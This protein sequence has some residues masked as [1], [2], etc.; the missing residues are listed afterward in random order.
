MIGAT[1]S[2]AHYDLYKETGNKNLFEEVLDK[3]VMDEHLDLDQDV[4]DYIMSEDI[5]EEKRIYILSN[6]LK[7][8]SL[9]VVNSFTK[10]RDCDT[11]THHLNEALLTLNKYIKV[12]QQEVKKYG[13]VFTPL[14]LVKEM[15]TT[16]PKEVWSNPNLK[17]L[18]PANGMGNFPL[19]VIYKLMKGLESWEPNVEKRYKHIIENM[20][21]VCEL[22]PKNA[23]MYLSLIDPKDDL[24]VN[25]YCGSFLEE[26]FDYHMKNVWDV[27]NFDIVLGNPPYNR[28]V[29][30]K[31]LNK[32]YSISE[33]VLFVHPS[34]WLI[35]ERNQY[36]P[37]LSSKNLVRDHL[38]S[39]ELFNGNKIFNI[40]LFVPC[41]ITYI[42]KS[43]KVD[44]IS[45]TDKIHNIS[46]VYG[47]INEINKYSN[48]KEYISIK[49]KIHKKENLYTH[50]LLKN[51]YNF[52]V[53]VSP[54]RG[55]VDLNSDI[56]MLLNDFY[57]FVAKDKKVETV[58][59]VTET[60]LSMLSSFGFNTEIEA[61]N[62][63]SY[64]KTDFARF[65][66]SIYKITQNQYSNIFEYVPWL[67]FDKEWTD[68][69]LYKHFD[70]T[71]IEVKFIENNIPKYY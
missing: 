52:Y 36:A 41:V 21:Y 69:K 39:I 66:L 33:K 16:L 7:D 54:I 42:N 59:K 71:E 58:K 30:L 22:Q 53:N 51:E 17:W 4:K 24:S 48:K 5:R 3:L 31:F 68:D 26:G 20:I 43:K 57:T 14:S 55:H 65:C 15:I 64:I 38:E 10:L 25:L 56:N 29:D 50:L 47:N 23:F 70:L 49:T 18:D 8:R 67:D 19:I 44:S 11:R 45:F 28:S 6:L 62:F 35:D 12:G 46:G 32:S 40:G 1:F 60:N 61:E 13:E 9:E 34:T 27:E 63:L 37:Y 2:Q